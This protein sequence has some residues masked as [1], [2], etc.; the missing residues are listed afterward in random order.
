[1]DGRGHGG[2]KVKKSL[3]CEVALALP[4]NFVSVDHAIVGIGDEV[5]VP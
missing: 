1:M 2:L 4:I 3:D 5:D